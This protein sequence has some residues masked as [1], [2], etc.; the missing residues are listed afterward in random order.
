MLKKMLVVLSCVCVTNIVYGQNVTADVTPR[1]PNNITYNS[2]YDAYGRVIYSSAWDK[3]YEAQWLALAAYEK[4]RT[5]TDKQVA[6]AKYTEA[7]KQINLALVAA[8]EIAEYKLLASQIY[9]S[10]GGLSYARN[11]F[12]KACALYEQQLKEYP[13]S[14][15][16][17]LQYAIAC[18]AGDARYY[19]DYNEYKIRSYLYANQ[20]LKLIEKYEK[21]FGEQQTLLPKFLAYVLLQDYAQT[22]KTAKRINYVCNENSLEYVSAEQYEQLVA[23]GQWLWRVSSKANAEK[24]F[25]LYNINEWGI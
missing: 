23:H 21:Q 15:T 8:P 7:I 17:N 6:N 1:K 14:I 12:S 13:E 4:A 3:A 10:R 22:E 20:T 16:L 9:R 18:Y 24:D 11:Y 19:P 25:L 2:A 5:T